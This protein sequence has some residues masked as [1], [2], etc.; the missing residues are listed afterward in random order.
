MRKAWAM[1]TMVSNSDFV[2]RWYSNTM[3]KK[4]KKLKNAK[5]RNDRESCEREAKLCVYKSSLGMLEEASR[6]RQ[7]DY[8][9]GVDWRLVGFDSLCNLFK[10]LQFQTFASTL[11]SHKHVEIFTVVK[12]NSCKGLNM[13]PV[14]TGSV[15]LLNDFGWVEKI[16][17]VCIHL[18]DTSRR[19]MC[20]ALWSDT[21]DERKLLIPNKTL[22]VF[23]FAMAR[24][25]EY[26]KWRKYGETPVY[27]RTLWE[28]SKGIE[29]KGR[30][31]WVSGVVNSDVV[32]KIASHHPPQ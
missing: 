16:L 30:N 25:V 6:K 9:R 15:T 24:H 2:F 23:W 12:K 4:R 31:E 32:K 20:H 14:L 18:N 29:R 27:D 7:Y 5:A 8:S 10:V 17:L 1:E 11:H 26:K 28:Q 3:Q 13:Y 22:H 19:K 21:A